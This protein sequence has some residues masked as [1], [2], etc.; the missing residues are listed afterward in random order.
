MLFITGISKCDVQASKHVHA[1]YLC[2]AK[3]GRLLENWRDS[4]EAISRSAYFVF[5]QTS[6]SVEGFLLVT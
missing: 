2:L 1:D 3:P 5:P 4:K 6:A